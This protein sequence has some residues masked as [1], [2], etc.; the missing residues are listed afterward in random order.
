MK[1]NDKISIYILKIKP[2]WW[3][4]QSYYLS[5]ELSASRRQNF[6]LS[7][8]ALRH[9]RGINKHIVGKK[10]QEKFQ[11]RIALYFS[12]RQIAY[13]VEVVLCCHSLF[14]KYCQI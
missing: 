1:I 12:C 10:R 11:K 7:E 2:Q 4:A 6:Q 3:V 9:F 14:N 5:P 8:R 13:S